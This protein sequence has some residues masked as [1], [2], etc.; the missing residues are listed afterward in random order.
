MKTLNS[1]QFQIYKNLIESAHGE[2][3]TI[4][5]VSWDIFSK[6]GD[7]FRTARPQSKRDAELFNYFMSIVNKRIK[8]IAR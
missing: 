8:Q 5:I 7:T 1:R 3:M 6:F 2:G 4:P